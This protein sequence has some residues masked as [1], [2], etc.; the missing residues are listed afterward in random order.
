MFVNVFQRSICNWNVPVVSI[1]QRTFF[2][3]KSKPIHN[4]VFNPTYLTWTLLWELFCSVFPYRLV[5]FAI[6]FTERSHF[7]SSSTYLFLFLFRTCKLNGREMVNRLVLII[8]TYASVS[9]ILQRY[10][11]SAHSIKHV[12]NLFF[13]STSCVSSLS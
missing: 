10:F 8:F 12:S 6:V 2:P 13:P 5:R 3:C 9:D 7:H 4:R 1:Y 11:I